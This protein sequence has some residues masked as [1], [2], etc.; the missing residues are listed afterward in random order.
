MK[1]DIR[2]Q[3]CIIIRKNGRYLVSRKMT[4]FELRWS[5]SR[6]DAWRTRS[7]VKAEKVAR[8]TGGIMVLFNPVVQ[9]TK[10][11]GAG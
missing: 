2:K 10:V 6:N 3:T 1:D 11:L 8:K 4:C 9:Q 7:R 5:E